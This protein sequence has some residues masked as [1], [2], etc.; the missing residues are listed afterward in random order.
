MIKHRYALILISMAMIS[1]W[2]TLSGSSVFQAT[3][4]LTPTD[5][6]IPSY[7]PTLPWCE[8]TPTKRYQDVIPV[9][10]IGAIST[11]DPLATD[12]PTPNL[13][14]TK[15]P[16]PTNTTQPNHLYKVEYNQS[17]L[18]FDACWP[19]CSNYTVY[20][21]TFSVTHPDTLIGKYWENTCT[22]NGGHANTIPSC[23]SN[24]SFSC[25][26]GMYTWSYT[27]QVY[28]R[29]S[30]KEYTG[31]T[32]TPNE[33]CQEA[34]GIDSVGSGFNL[35]AGTNENWKYA[36]GSDAGSGLKCTFKQYHYYWGNHEPAAQ[37]TITPTATPE[38]TVTPNCREYTDDIYE[39]ADPF[40]EFDYNYIGNTCISLFSGIELSL[41]DLP[42]VLLDAMDFLD[43]TGIFDISAVP[44]LEVPGLEIC[45]DQYQPII[46]IMDMDLVTPLSIMITLVV[47][48]GLINEF[49]S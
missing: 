38:M 28:K 34:G 45:L 24:I 5:T 17:E 37:P 18:V 19:N 23:N 7:T 8:Y 36:I 4:T 3:E 27:P 16:T 11:I 15:T 41:D 40:A 21:D 20:G 30:V 32:Q 22:A 25:Y 9:I 31:L 6:V 39:D 47:I 12:T 35:A 44:E 42:S 10:E 43:S 14:H 1:G 13:T 46:T 48:G 33:I 29:C 49:R 2:V 26:V